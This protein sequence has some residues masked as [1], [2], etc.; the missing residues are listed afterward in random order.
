MSATAEQPLTPRQREVLKAL[1]TGRP[2]KQLADEL[3]VT[4]NT[5]RIHCQQIYARLQIHSAVEAVRAAG[6][7]SLL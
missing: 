6:K 3:G 5:L 2:R 7:M 1:A 4:H